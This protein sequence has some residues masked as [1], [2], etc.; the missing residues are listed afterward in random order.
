ME[1][2]RL[3]FMSMGFTFLGIGIV[4]IAL[5]ILP[6]TPFVLVA[7]F[8]FGKSSKRLERWISSNRY[9]GSYIENYRTKKG[10][11]RDVKLKSITF[12]WAMLILSTLIFSHSFYIVILLVLVGIAVTTHPVTR[13]LLTHYH[14]RREI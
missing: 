5:P 6:T 12:L 8:C 4:G 11:P 2:T 10:V 7:A 3:F 1:L 14:N 9:F 13:R